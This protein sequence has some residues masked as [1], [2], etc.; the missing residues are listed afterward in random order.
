MGFHRAAR[1][2]LGDRRQ[3]AGGHRSPMLSPG[4]V[5][6][7]GDG[8]FAG[9]ALAG[10]AGVGEEARGADGFGDLSVARE[11]PAVVHRDG[12]DDLAAEQEDGF[13]GDGGGVDFPQGTGE[14]QARGAF[15]GDEDSGLFAG[16]EVKGGVHF[17]VAELAAVVGGGRSLG[18]MNAVGDA[19]AGLFGARGFGQ[20]GLAAVA[21]GAVKFSAV[22][23]VLA[24]AAAES[25]RADGKLRLGVVG[26]LF[27]TPAL[28]DHDGEGGAQHRFADRRRADPGASGVGPRLGGG[29]AVALFPAVARDLA[30]DGGRRPP[31][32]LGDP[33]QGL[34]GAQVPFNQGSLCQVQSSV[35][36]KTPF[37]EC[38]TEY[39]DP[40]QPPTGGS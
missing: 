26:D 31:E 17:P 1:Q 38:C 4:Q 22:G 15:R 7:E 14:R 20:S 16:S 36:G 25:G 32:G 28:A 3:A 40:H 10:T 6:E 12:A 18:I 29:G 2:A 39:D 23:A 37:Q 34:P 24:D 30:A 9:A 8:V 5:A 11:L 33:P 27:G 35:H 13:G 21:E 19:V